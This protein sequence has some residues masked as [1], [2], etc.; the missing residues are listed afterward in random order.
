VT[1]WRLCPD[2]RT[3]DGPRG[4]GLLRSGRVI[5][6]EKEV[7][8]L[9]VQETSAPA[10]DDVWHSLKGLGFATSD[11]LNH[12][13]RN[14]SFLSALTEDDLLACRSRLM[15]CKVEV[16]GCGGLGSAI[17]LQLV[18]LGLKK[19][20]LYDSDRVEASN[21]NRLLWATKQDVGS[22][23][24]HALARHLV[25]R[26]DVE[27]EAFA[28]DLGAG[29]IPSPSPDT[30][31]VLVIDD[32]QKVRE[33]LRAVH[34]SGLRSYIFAGYAGSICVAGPL[35][36]HRSEPCPFCG[37]TELIPRTR[38]GFTPPSAIVNNSFLASYVVAQICLWLAGR[39]VLAGTQWSFDLATSLSSVRRLA[40]SDECSVCRTQ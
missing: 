23:K 7:I 40:R 20:A 37:G 19:L 14:E 9:L 10:L 27:A 4:S 13:D 5:W 8:S 30:L 26:F 36:S 34:R 3:V 15:Q 2:V 21:L 17:A 11:A 38:P 32:M 16:V 29:S 35:W 1:R 18:A 31:L 24:V 39:P 12:A 33:L 22:P 28:F 6:M 25:A